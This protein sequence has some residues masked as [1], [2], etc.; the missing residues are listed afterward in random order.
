MSQEENK[1]N[2][3]LNQTV[4]DSPEE[5]TNAEGNTANS[6]EQVNSPEIDNLPLESIGSY[7]R[8][9]ELLTDEE[10]EN[11]SNPTAQS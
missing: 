8:L 7:A 10:K 5:N 4:F 9:E 11:T 3:N 6:S 1:E 2:S